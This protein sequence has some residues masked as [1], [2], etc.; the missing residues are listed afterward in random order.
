MSFFE[1]YFSRILFYQSQAKSCLRISRINKSNKSCI[2]DLQISFSINSIIKD[3]TRRLIE[4]LVNSDTSNFACIND[5]LSLLNSKVSWNTDNKL[6]S[7]QSIQSQSGLNISKNSSQYLLRDNFLSLS[8]MV[9]IKNNSSIFKTYFG[10]LVRLFISQSLFI[11][12]PN[13]SSW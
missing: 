9:D 6:S 1:N 12:N 5:R 11:E 8:L 10:K 13:K 3:V 7:F 4:Q 2:I